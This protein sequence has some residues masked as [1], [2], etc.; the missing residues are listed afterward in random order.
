MKCAYKSESSENNSIMKFDVGEA[1]QKMINP[2]FKFEN[3]LIPTILL[4][5]IIKSLSARS[6]R[7]P[8]AS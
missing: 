1:H 8:Y 7:R 5:K 3:D 6:G 2:P 4:M